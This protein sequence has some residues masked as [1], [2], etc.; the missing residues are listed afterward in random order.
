[1]SIRKATIKNVNSILEAG[2]IIDSLKSAEFESLVGNELSL[3][4]ED[5]EDNMKFL[6]NYDV[7]LEDSDPFRI[8]SFDNL[9]TYIYVMWQGSRNNLDIPEL[10]SMYVEKSEETPDINKTLLR[11]ILRAY[12]SEDLDAAIEDVK[13]KIKKYHDEIRK[14]ETLTSV[15]DYLFRR[16]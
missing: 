1:M 16:I 2:K 14:L 13:R 12:Y 8:L 9:S 11:M 3:S 5:T 4:F 7:T 10:V 6:E 15:S